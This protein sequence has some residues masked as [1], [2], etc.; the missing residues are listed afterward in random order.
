MLTAHALARLL[1]AGPDVEVTTWDPKEGEQSAIEQ[2]IATKD[3]VVL[4]MDIQPS[5]TVDGAE[6]VWAADESAAR[7]IEL[8]QARWARA[9]TEWVG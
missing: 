4:G 5:W 3:S 7:G 2:V 9:K 6:V 8:A 1:L